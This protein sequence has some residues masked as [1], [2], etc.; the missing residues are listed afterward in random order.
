MR[1]GSRPAG[2]A[3]KELLANGRS[4]PL[5][6]VKTPAG[7]YQRKAAPPSPLV[8]LHNRTMQHIESII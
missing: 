1:L 3:M 8:A 4:I 2:E 6:N 5:E 7:D